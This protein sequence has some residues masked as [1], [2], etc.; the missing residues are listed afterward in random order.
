MYFVV[1]VLLRMALSDELGLLGIK[2]FGVL[3]VEDYAGLLVMMG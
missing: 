2:V 3:D 1:G